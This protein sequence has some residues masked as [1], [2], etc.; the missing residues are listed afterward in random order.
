MSIKFFTTGGTIDKIYFDEKSTFE[1]GD[2]YLENLLHRANVSFDYSISELLRKDSLQ[3]T[4]E[5]RELIVK[6]VQQAKEEK[7]VI[8]HGTDTMTT[9]GIA[10]KDVPGKT[11]ILTGSMQPARFR[12]S[13]A[14]FNIGTAVGSAQTLP[15]GVYIAMNGE[16][17]DPAKATKN[18][19][20]KRF[21]EA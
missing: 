21:E 19:E 20:R 18:S 7:V 17:V 2:S 10:L 3:L 9:T 1:V 14:A 4:D 13:D 12:D 15:H 16:I 5:D 8:T 11:I 6:S